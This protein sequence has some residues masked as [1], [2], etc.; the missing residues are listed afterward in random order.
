MDEF[1]TPQIARMFSVTEQT[2]KAWSA[3]FSRYLSPTATPTKGKKRRFTREDIE[4]LALVAEYRETGQSFEEIHLAL[5]RNDR[6]EV[7]SIADELVVASP[8]TIIT[9]L[10]DQVAGL[11]HEII[12][13]G[14]EKS[15]AEGQVKLLK[16]QLA[17]KERLIRQLYQENAQL[18]VEAKDD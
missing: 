9:A 16:E 10:K 1:A 12:R 4:V 11:Q 6:G 14:T 2:V 17:E 3:E 8:T 7:P 13:L 15:E 18:K 5:Q